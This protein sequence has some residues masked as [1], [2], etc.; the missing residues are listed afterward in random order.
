MNHANKID[1]QAHTINQLLG[2]N[3]F[4]VDYFQREYSWEQKH[5]EQLVTDLC[6]SFENAY[7]EGDER[8][9]VAKYAHYYLG[10][11]VVS[12]K[13]T[14]KSIVDGQQRL[15]SLT[16]F[17]IYLSHRQQDVGINESI[18]NL[19]YSTQYGVK[20]FNILDDVLAGNLHGNDRGIV[21][22]ALW[23][24][25][26]YEVKESDSATMRN[27]VA[28]Y[29]DIDSNFPSELRTR[30]LLPMFIDWVRFN[31]LL[32]EITA[33]SDESAYDIFE[34][35]NDRGLNLTATEMLKGYLVS[36]FDDVQERDHL[37]QEWKK[38]ILELQNF[39][40]D[41]DQKFFQAWLRS[42]YAETIRQSKAG[43]Q[44]EDFEKIGTRF[45]SWV[46][47]NLKK[48]G[49]HHQNNTEFRQLIE[50][51]LF[52]QK[53]YVKLLEAQ[54]SEIKGLEH[55]FYH[56]QW[57][58]AESLSLP[59]MLA[60]LQ[61]TDSIDIQYQKM[62]LVARYLETFAV[63]RSVNYRNFSASSIRYTM[64]SLVKDLRGK[65]VIELKRAL[66]DRV[67]GAEEQLTGITQHTFAL[68][69]MNRVFIKFLLSRICGFVDR[70][71]GEPTNFSSYFAK[72]DAK[73]FEVEHVWANTFDAH[74][75]EFQQATDFG[76]YRN[77]LGALLLLPRGTN[78]SYGNKPY[79]EKLELY[80]LQ[81]LLVQ[82]L[83]PI[84]YKNNPNFT[85]MVAKYGLPFRSHQQFKKA[86]IDARQ[87]LMERICQQI[88][89]WQ[90]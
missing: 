48:V 30:A 2:S 64:Y 70:E 88:W 75:D 62:D 44:N 83:H 7:A 73:P 25:E 35:M 28:R 38:A 31:V 17:L 37:N 13:G 27:M 77:K 12:I 1:A 63:T 56:A 80:V 47:E 5:I 86:D 58:V 40:K 69:G 61:I 87:E 21:F 74:R 60:P 78:Q 90:E 36:R 26:T 65:N 68:H 89:N 59:L 54:K 79:E 50:N 20:S 24:N 81:N 45:H 43:S 82:T 33:Y 3:K 53:A 52:Y 19:V 67:L 14:K 46:R 42:Q 49:I 32:V 66:T 4:V 9:D 55:V 10:P 41:E 18:E 72:T 71:A 15:T 11:Y 39:G 84:T 51:M 76:A 85:T 6:T 29:A 34:S 23:N 22:E 16:L 57:R 8:P